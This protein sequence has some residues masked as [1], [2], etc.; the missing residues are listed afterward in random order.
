MQGGVFT[1][2]KAIKVMAAVVALVLAPI[3]VAEGGK[4]A[5]LDVQEAILSTNMAK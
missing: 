1:V 2:N 4:V 5:V 3:A